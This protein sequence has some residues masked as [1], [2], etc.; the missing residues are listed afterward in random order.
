MEIKRTIFWT[1]VATG[2]GIP[3]TVCRLPLL[4]SIWLLK[5]YSQFLPMPSRQLIPYGLIPSFFYGSCWYLKQLLGGNQD[6]WTTSKYRL[7]LLQLRHA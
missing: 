1:R 2:L 4:L 3:R 6:W 5:N 7:I